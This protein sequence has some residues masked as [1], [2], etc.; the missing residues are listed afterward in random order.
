VLEASESVEEIVLSFSFIGTGSFAGSRL[1]CSHRR[2][3][4]V[5][6]SSA[7]GERRVLAN[8]EGVDRM[9]LPQR[10]A[11]WISLYGVALLIAGQVRGVKEEVPCHTNG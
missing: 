7:C 8:L 1:G 3:I 4:L 9:N 5:V 10:D 2:P 11:G 6:V